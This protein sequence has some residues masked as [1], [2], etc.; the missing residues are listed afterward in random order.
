ML[1]RAALIANSIELG[2]IV[3]GLLLAW[4]LVFSPAARARRSATPSTLP[5]WD[6]TPGDFLMFLWVVVCGGILAQVLSTL[7]FTPLALSEDGKLVFANVA[8]QMGELAG[9]ALYYCGLKGGRLPRDFAPGKILLSGAATFAIAIPFVTLV[10]LIWQLLMQLCGLPVEKQEIIGR[11]VNAESPA[12]LAGM[13]ALATLTAPIAE[14]LVFRAGIFRYVRTRLPRWGALLLPAC[15][16]AALHQN[17][18]SFAQLVVLGIIFSL[19]Y[20]RTGRIGTAIVAHALFNAQSV[21]LVLIDPS[22]AN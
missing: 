16:F 12:L 19:A 13:I 7:L 18:A 17:L 21:V 9:V 3:A 2:L 8:L 20:E 5:A 15:L 10:G 14:E 11:L 22:A 4:Q 6:A 1:S